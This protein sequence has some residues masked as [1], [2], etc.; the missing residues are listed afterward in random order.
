MVIS[1]MVSQKEW[2]V[3][4]GKV[5]DVLSD[6]QI[7]LEKAAKEEPTGYQKI[8]YEGRAIEVAAIIKKFAVSC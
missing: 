5:L 8:A 1:E 2:I 7:Y 6:Y 3:K 4:W